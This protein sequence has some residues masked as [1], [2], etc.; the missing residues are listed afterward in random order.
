ME[1]DEIIA[2]IRKYREELA[3]KFDYD[4]DAIVD[5]LR[6][7]ESESGITTVFLK[8]KKPRPKSKPG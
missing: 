3:E 7:K 6:R 4:L 1:D 5:D 2:E 8:P